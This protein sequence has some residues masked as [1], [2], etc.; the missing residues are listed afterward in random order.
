[1]K[2]E[3]KNL[4]EGLVCPKCKKGWLYQCK[5]GDKGCLH[6]TRLECDFTREPPLGWVKWKPLPLDDSKPSMK[7]AVQLAHI[8]EGLA[9]QVPLRSHDARC[10]PHCKGWAIFYRDGG[11]LLHICKCD[12]CAILEY[13]EDAAFC[14][15]AAGLIVWRQGSM[16]WVIGVRDSE[17]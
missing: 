14:A 10:D 11:N 3:A 6:C 16:A 12:D 2:I 7:D 15:E 5:T 1:M 17:G 9:S 8:A 13:D 4:I